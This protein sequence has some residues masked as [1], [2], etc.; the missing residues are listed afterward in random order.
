MNKY[1]FELDLETV[2]TMSVIINQIKKDTRVL[3]FGPAKGRLT[4]YLSKAKKCQ[5]DIVE[6]DE[7]SGKEAAKYAKKAFVGVE[8]GNIENYRWEHEKYTYEY[9]IFADV[10]E[11]LYNPKEVLLRAKRLL[12]ETGKI[13][14]SIPNTAHNSIIID[15]INDEFKYL[16]TGLLDNTHIRF[17]TYKSFKRLLGEI[18]LVSTL[19]IPIY[20]RV[21]F[22]EI[23]NT[24]KSVQ[25]KVEK[26]LRQRKTGSIYQYVFELEPSN[27]QQAIEC[28]LPSTQLD[29]YCDY[30]AVCYIKS[31]IEGEYNESATSR[32]I[33]RGD[34]TEVLIDLSSFDNIEEI[35]FD[36]LTQN[37]IYLLEEVAI[38]SEGEW[39][40]AQPVGSNA[41]AQIGGLFFFETEDPQIYFE[42][43]RQNVDQI[44]V[45]F[46][47]LDD[48]IEDFSMYHEI[49][50]VMQ[51]S[52]AL[53]KTYMQA[54][55]EHRDTDI[56]ILRREIDIRED[57]LKDM[58]N[59]IA[60]KEEDISELKKIINHRDKDITL[61]NHVVREKESHWQE[62][63]EVIQ[64]RDRDISILKDEIDQRDRALVEIKKQL[65]DLNKEMKAIKE[66]KTY[67]II[68]KLRK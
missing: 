29:F 54:V 53:D 2:N 46:K 38:K 50:Q 44:K 9:I 34:Q 18:G 31:R 32:E 5:V 28:G 48:C 61:L 7:E 57:K 62:V 42:I 41:T 63:I 1:D 6:I 65:E 66:T 40:N 49:I 4:K 67:K 17:F 23:E 12:S 52:H 22:N 47:I 35:R 30:E 26:A 55:I 11:H 21:G 20:S 19:E 25:A 56:E 39:H 64:H 68:N 58:A 15:L 33:Y 16:T 8:E 59:V 37:A 3:E 14:V 36:P 24:Y 60:H 43:Q 45:R 13:L 51:A 10:L 27:M